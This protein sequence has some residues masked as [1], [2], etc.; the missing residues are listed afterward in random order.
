VYVA[1]ATFSPNFPTTADAFSSV[2]APGEEDAFLTK[3][4][5]RRAGAAGLEY[6]TY[7]GG[8]A[9]DRALG[10]AVEGH[11]AT[12]TGFTEAAD[13]PVTGNAYDGT[14]NGG[15]DTIVTRIDTQRAGAAGL[16]YSTYLGGSGPD[17][18]RGL[19]LKGHDAYV[20]GET[21]SAD[22]PV[23]ANA[24]DTTFNGGAPPPPTDAVVTRL[25]TGR[26]PAGLEYSTYLGG[27]GNDSGR[28]IAVNGHEAF[29]TGVVGSADF[30]VTANAFDPTFN[31]GG[32]CAAPPTP[33][34]TCDAFVT[35]LDT[36]KAGPAGLEYSTYL[37]GGG[38]DLGRGIDL[39]G[40]D[41]FVVGQTSSPNFPVTPDAFQSAKAGPPFGP[42]APDMFVTRLDTERAGA[43][44]LEYSTYLGGSGLE[45]GF[46]IT[47]KGDDAYVAGGS[48]SPDFPTTPNAYDRTFNGGFADATV[49]RLDTK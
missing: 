39:T 2:N 7:I 12:I 28:A 48:G 25:D 27:S 20:T 26:G 18:G 47:V 24:F 38:A 15:Q 13:Y 16:E 17:S 31:G 14:H 44:G 34:S 35:R 46:G 4:D 30:P 23:T 37:G 45:D 6:S 43:A 19:A 41:A 11:D 8:S 1:G 9:P 21:G 32:P 36:G 42:A 40:H 5:T 22:Y 33:F 29:V 10:L 49:S 3:L